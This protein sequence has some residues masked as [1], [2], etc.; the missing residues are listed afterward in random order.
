[1]SAAYNNIVETA[2]THNLD[3]RSAAF[4]FAIL[5]AIDVVRERGIFP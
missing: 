5:R 3:M 1:M 4:V 2:K